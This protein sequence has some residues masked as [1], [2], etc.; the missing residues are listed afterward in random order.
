MPRSVIIGTAMA[1]VAAL[2]TSSCCGN[3]CSNPSD[4]SD[5]ATTI[6]LAQNVAPDAVMEALFQGRIAR[7]AQGCLR[8]TDAE[9]ATVIWPYGSRLEARADGPHVVDAAGR[10]LGPVG[11]NFRFGGGFVP[12]VAHV[13]LSDADRTLAETRCPGTYFVVGDTDLTP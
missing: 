7:D 10:D 11:G 8:T 1:A 2:A 3:D 12:G 4:A 5:E 9:S 13:S 6:F